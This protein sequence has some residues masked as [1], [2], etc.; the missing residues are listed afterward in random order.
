MTL[1]CGCDFDLDG[2]DWWWEVVRHGEADE[3]D[4]TPYPGKR[5]TR[6]ISCGTRIVP[7]DQHL[8]INRYRHPRTFVEERIYGEDGEI[9][10]APARMCEDCAEIFGALLAHGYCLSIEEPMRD[11][12]REHWEITGYMPEAERAVEAGK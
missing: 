1:S 11:Q 12:L 8:A 2:C 10:I 7:G 9:E 6:C 5:S 3:Q 4:T